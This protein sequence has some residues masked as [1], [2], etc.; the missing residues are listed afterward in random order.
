MA[1]P[2]RLGINIRLTVGD[3]HGSWTDAV[4]RILNLES[5]WECHVV[6]HVLSALLVGIEC[7]GAEVIISIC[8]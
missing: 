1:F 8:R 7:D 6:M 5:G 3:A 2:A 4:S